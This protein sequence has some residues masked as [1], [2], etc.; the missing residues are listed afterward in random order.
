MGYTKL[1]SSPYKAVSD[2]L[3]TSNPGA[4][5]TFNLASKEECYQFQNK[6][7]VIRRATNL[8]DNKTLIIHPESTIYGTFSKE[9]KEVMG[10]EDNLLRLS[11]G[12]ENIEDL[13]KDILQALG[14]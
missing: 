7:K 5:L 9:M 12:L 10:I 4:M 11:V 14:E 8:F 2:K 13:K 3:F 1:E 6:L